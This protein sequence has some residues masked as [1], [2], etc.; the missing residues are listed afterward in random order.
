MVGNWIGG[1][2]HI[3]I[4]HYFSLGSYDSDIKF[5]YQVRFIENILYE[6]NLE[7]WLHTP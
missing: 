6:K 2:G 3:Y 7:S 5:K 1:R 4:Y